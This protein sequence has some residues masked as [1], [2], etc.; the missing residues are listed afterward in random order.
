MGVTNQAIKPRERM[1]SISNLI[2]CFAGR[3][4]LSVTLASQHFLPESRGLLAPRFS[5]NKGIGAYQVDLACWAMAVGG[6]HLGPASAFGF[7]S[8]C[9][10]CW[11]EPLSTICRQRFVKSKGTYSIDLLVKREGHWR[12][13]IRLPQETSRPESY[14]SLSLLPHPTCCIA[15]AFSLPTLDNE[16]RFVRFMIPTRKIA[17]SQIRF[18]WMKERQEA[19]RIFSEGGG[20][21]VFN[22]PT[23]PL[24]LSLRP[25]D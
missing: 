22:L 2:S 19:T 10:E 17:A 7:D 18:V 12:P 5:S 11:I 25:S 6:C 13:Q 3:L 8:I 21:I 16:S 14:G 15:S 4:A 20:Y 23:N 24:S 9:A 1:H